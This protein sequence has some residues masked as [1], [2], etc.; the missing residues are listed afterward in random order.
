MFCIQ[1]GN[2]I[3]LTRTGFGFT[4][5]YGSGYNQYDDDIILL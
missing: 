1:F 2:F 5:I 3:D 4:N